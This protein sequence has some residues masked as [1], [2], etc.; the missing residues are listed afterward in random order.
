[1]MKV[2]VGVLVA[3]VLWFEA[4]TLME[5]LAGIWAAAVFWFKTITLAGVLASIWAGVIWGLQAV[6]FVVVGGVILLCAFAPLFPKEI[7]SEE[8]SGSE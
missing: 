1:M 3:V 2:I 4:V 8:T 5:V 7:C 6:V